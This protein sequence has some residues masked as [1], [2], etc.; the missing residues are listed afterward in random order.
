MERDSS[1]LWLETFEL[2]SK[3]GFIALDSDVKE[4][5]TMKGYCLSAVYKTSSDDNIP[6]FIITAWDCKTKLSVICENEPTKFRVVNTEKANFPCIPDKQNLR[7]KRQDDVSSLEPNF[8]AKL[9]VRLPVNNGTDPS[10]PN[11]P[12]IPA[13]TRKYWSHDRK[14]NRPDS[15]TTMEP[16]PNSGSIVRTPKNSG[17]DKLDLG[18]STPSEPTNSASTGGHESSGSQ[19][20]TS[21]DKTSGIGILP[22]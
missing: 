16:D 8:N 13:S 15:D 18:S 9:Y 22:K 5:I 4:K 14:K 20:N 1:N 3:N 21:T 10:E 12:N 2:I 19:S 7:K 11:A 17:A 6:S